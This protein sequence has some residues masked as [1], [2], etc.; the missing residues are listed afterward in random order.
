MKHALRTIAAVLA[1]ALTFDQLAFAATG[2]ANSPATPAA[3][4]ASAPAPA[5]PIPSQIATAHTVFLDNAGGDAN[6]PLPVDQS[7]TDVYAALQTWG[8]Y[9]L[10]ATPAEAELVFQLRDIA[11]ITDISG[12][13][14][15][16]YSITSPAFQLTILDA[17]TNVAL[18]TVTSPVYITGKKE[19]RAHW[20]SIAVTNLVSRVKVLANEPLSATESADLNTFPANHGLRTALI[21]AG[22]AA[23]LG[24]GLTFIIR[25][26]MKN[27][28]DAFCKANNIPLNECAGG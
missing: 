15:G 13:R 19:V 4:Q 27:S 6:F 18:W 8:H 2:Q 9:K 7:Y 1:F 26:H 23:A 17:K 10:V 22:G 5:S 20:A 25:N 24:V 3:P 12:T 14:A 11:P 16:T 28:Q 21:F